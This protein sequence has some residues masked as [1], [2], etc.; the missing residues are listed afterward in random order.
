MYEQL[1]T[2]FARRVYKRVLLPHVGGSFLGAAGS[3]LDPRSSWVQC[4]A[5]TAAWDHKFAATPSTLIKEKGQQEEL[6]PL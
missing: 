3:L 2:C 6:Y 1:E 4:G 5:S